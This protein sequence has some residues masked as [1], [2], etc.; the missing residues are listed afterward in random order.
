MLARWTIRQSGHGGR[1]RA[2][3]GADM[4]SIVR[5]MV[6]AGLLFASRTQAEDLIR[7]APD[8]RTAC[9]LAADQHRLVLLH[10]YNDNCEPCVRVERNVFS[11]PQVAEAVAQNY[12]AVKVH[13]GKEAQLANRYRVRSWPTDVFVTPT[14]LEV[15]RSV[16]PQ[17]PEDY[18]SLVNQVAQQTGISA[19]RQW[20]GKL[21]DAAAPLA[22]AAVAS[23]GEA[24]GGVR[25]VAEQAA[26]TAQDNYAQGQQRWAAALEQF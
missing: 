12:H 6:L 4:K 16:S 22:G 18:I 5:A 10:F 2:T 21:G 24:A 23:A 17:K 26:V 19:A 9:Q 11:Q 8:Y 13:A 14:G 7:W 3:E 1:I 20:Q 25:Q 15:Y